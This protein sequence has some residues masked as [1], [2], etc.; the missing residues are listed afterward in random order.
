MLHTTRKLSLACAL[1]SFDGYFVYTPT[2]TELTRNIQKTLSLPPDIFRKKLAALRHRGGKT[3]GARKTRAADPEEQLQRDA[4][5]MRGLIHDDGETEN[6]DLRDVIHT[7][8]LVE[9]HRNSRQPLT[10]R[11]RNTSLLDAVAKSLDKR[12]TAKAKTKKTSE[13]FRRKPCFPQKDRR[14]K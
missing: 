8:T 11:E 5:E 4:V 13:D 9:T 10:R 7:G 6:T 12:K 1:E 2:G 14:T 3:H